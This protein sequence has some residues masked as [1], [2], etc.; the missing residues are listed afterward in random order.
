MIIKEIELHN[1]RSYVNLHL[2]LPSGCILFKGDIGSGK[3]TILM[4]IEFALFGNSTSAM[5]HN[6]LRKG[7]T[8]GFV[9][10]VFEEAGN[11]YEIYRALVKK[12]RGIQNS[13]SYVISPAGKQMLSATDIR[14]YVLNLMG[15]NINSKKRRSLPIVTYAI[16]TPQETMKSIL[17][18]GDEERI[19]VI[20]KIFKLDEY[21]IAR[22]NADIVAAYLR[23]RAAAAEQYKDEKE[24]IDDELAIIETE[25]NDKVK[26]QGEYESKLKE[27]TKL[28]DEL[29]NKVK[30]MTEK[31]RQYEEYGKALAAL[32]SGLAHV[33][34][35][36]E[37]TRKEL[38][39]LAKEERKLGLLEQEASKYEKLRKAREELS[40]KMKKFEVL[41]RKQA[42]LTAKLEKL[43]AEVKK[44]AE[45]DGQLKNLQEEQE[46][47]RKNIEDMGNIEQKLEDLEARRRALEVAIRRNE[48][49]LG[50]KRHEKAEF[51]KLGAVCPTCKR[52]L[53]EEHKHNLVLSAE[54]DISTLESTIKALKSKLAAVLNEQANMKKEAQNKRELE[55]KAAK[56]ESNIRHINSRLD[57][58]SKAKH[59]LAELEKELD[60]I[61]SELSAYENIE[62]EYESMEL[63]IKGLESKWRDYIMI[64][65]RVA[66][67]GEVE[68]KF[69]ELQDREL[70]LK[71]KQDEI[72]RELEKLQYSESEFD[73]LNKEY[74]T[75]K[76]TIVS[77]QEKLG[78]VVRELEELKGRKTTKLQRRTELDSK[79]ELA[80]KLDS[81]KNWLEQ[82]FKRG[83][84]SIE[85]M[86]LSSIN[87]EFRVLFEKWFADL[88]RESDYAATIDEN[89]KPVIRYEQYDMNIDTLSGGERT[90]VALAYRLALNTM[91]KRALGLT[92]NLLILD[93]P[94]DGFSQDQLSKLKD[95]FDG[96]DTDQII[97]VSHEEALRNLADVVFMVEKQDGKSNITK[98]E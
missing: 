65:E 94:T 12:G 52:T 16:Y 89:F 53:P 41:K 31:R 11:D 82:E 8:S 76:L 49:K 39:E 17:E 58:L 80:E 34:R 78:A 44:G 48:E 23:E 43:R 93:E 24:H 21:R 61:K 28:S 22:D 30:L 9:R 19:E 4:A 18:G 38:E 47:I 54:K 2:R 64:R 13:E 74:E 29:G 91:V 59:E 67:K 45:L 72:N 84:D 68:L 36:Q 60:A 25:L 40:T 7:T 5:Y 42:S 86:R 15:L 87:E 55:L 90:A 66:R 71:R 26:E 63:Q 69:K 32:E 98:A 33:R 6:L 96:M 37:T 3:T 95:I 79:I 46:R 77:Y 88:M 14:S 62:Q 35:E 10:V 97:I 57:E 27:L 51:M 1:V 85:K 92:S 83:M 50:D 20:R 70:E 73:K 75:L 56:L 81:M